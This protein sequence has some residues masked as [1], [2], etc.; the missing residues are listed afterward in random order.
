MTSK[1][2]KSKIQTAG[3]RSGGRL[4][5]E[6]IQTRMRSVPGWRGKD[7]RKAIARTYTFPGFR[8]SIAFVNLVAELAEARDHHPDIDIRYNKVT[9]TLSTHSAGGL[10]EKDFDLAR[11][12]DQAT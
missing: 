10:T 3:P 1:I 8:A 5:A 4:K 2:K 6:R 12:I 11:L 7:R 9:L